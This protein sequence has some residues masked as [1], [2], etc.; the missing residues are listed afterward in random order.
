MKVLHFFKTYW[1]DTFGGVERTIHAIVKGT[2]KY[3]V[4]SDVLSLSENPKSNSV[5][6]DGH[7]AHKAKLAFEFASTGFSF[8]VFSRFKELAHE[9]DIVH[10][11][12]PWPLMDLVHLTTQH[13]KPTV[14]TYHSDVVKQKTLRHLYRPLMSRFLDRVD[15]IVATSPNYLQSSDVLNAYRG[16]TSVIPLGLN[17]TDYPFPGAQRLEKWRAELPRRF[18]LF[19]GV[20]RYYKG[21]QF[22]LEAAKLSDVE[23]VI[24]G[25][26]PQGDAL[27]RQAKSLSLTN[28]RFLGSLADEDKIAVM[29]LCFCVIFPSHLRSEAFGLS[30]VEASMLGKPMISCEI[31]TGTSYVN[32]DNQTGIVVKPA[33]A[34][35]LSN[36]MLALGRDEVM[37]K[38]YGVAA[39]QRYAANFT[40]DK[41]AQSYANLYYASG[42][43][44]AGARGHAIHRNNQR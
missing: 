9:A 26:G 29:Q 10:F 35:S 1:P 14:L 5:V 22:L 7:D 6:F 15:H 23:I 36:A 42:A 19:V 18:F 38:S 20:L 37:A 41:M 24:I 31:S 12:F 39:R 11:H 28:V 13:S 43:K 33:D 32:L 44:M 4:H 27:K 2:E 25:D 30:L 17:E 21:V 3:G 34:M 16:K 40:A 8:D